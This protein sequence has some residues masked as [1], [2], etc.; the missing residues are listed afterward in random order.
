MNKVQRESQHN[1][2]LFCCL[3]FTKQIFCWLMPSSFHLSFVVILT[4]YEKISCTHFDKKWKNQLY[5]LC[6]KMTADFGN[7]VAKTDKKRQMKDE[8]KQT[9]HDQLE[10]RKEEK[11]G[12]T[13]PCRFV[14]CLW[15][16]GFL[17]DQWAPAAP[18]E[19]K[20]CRSFVSVRA[21]NAHAHLAPHARRR[22]ATVLTAPLRLQ[23]QSS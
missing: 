23:Q 8:M 19:L 1:R 22:L 4:N 17:L 5:C 9:K 21:F 14:Y 6:L 10:K 12:N 13:G 2:N 11:K 15:R 7:F 16:G 20:S 18:L 3:A